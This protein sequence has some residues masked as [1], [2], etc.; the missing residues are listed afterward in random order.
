MLAHAYEGDLWPELGSWA[1]E[2][3]EGEKKRE[4]LEERGTDH[5]RHKKRRF[6]EMAEDARAKGSGVTFTP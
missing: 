4:E 1:P 6:Q 3:T 5:V 2:G